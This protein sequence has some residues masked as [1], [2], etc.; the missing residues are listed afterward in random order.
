VLLTD[1]HTHLYSEEFDGDRD[2]LIQ[3]AIDQGVERFFMPN[4]DSS[5]IEPMFEVEK[6]FPGKAF[7]MM[8][9]HPCYVKE[10]W[11]EELKIVEKWLNERSF[12]AVGEIGIDLYWDKTFFEEQKEAFRLQIEMANERKLPIV[13]HTRNSFDETVA[14]L[15]STAKNAPHGIFHCFSGNEEQARQVIDMGFKIGIG[16]VVTFKN[17]GVDKAIANIPMEHIVLE[18]DAP[19]LAPVPF[20]GKRND[21]AYILKVAEKISEIKGISVME[22]ARVTTENSVGVFGK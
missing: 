16:G 13:I 22:V 19:Y 7:A 17:G 6:R 11:K 1:T 15:K 18:T 2:R 8:G 14:V 4:I 10:N 21:P 3:E 20:R 9:L 5:S 12:V